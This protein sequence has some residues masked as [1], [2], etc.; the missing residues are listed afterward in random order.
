MFGWMIKKFTDR[1]LKEVMEKESAED[2]LGC[3]FAAAINAMPYISGVWTAATVMSLSCFSAVIF[4]R[5][6]KIRLTN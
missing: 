3:F 2:G 4:I 1:M 6:L 5:F